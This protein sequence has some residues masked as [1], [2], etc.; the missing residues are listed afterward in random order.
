MMNC[1]ECK[2]FVKN[3]NLCKCRANPGIVYY[4]A[5]YPSEPLVDSCGAFEKQ[6]SQGRN[7]RPARAFRSK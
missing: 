1:L 7:G 2:N 6:K 3:G 4:G 5:G